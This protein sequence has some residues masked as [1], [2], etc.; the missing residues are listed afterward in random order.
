MV[1]SKYDLSSINMFHSGLSV[2]KN[3]KFIIN[4][5]AFHLVGS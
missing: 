5:D 1:S 3:V 4:D 2:G